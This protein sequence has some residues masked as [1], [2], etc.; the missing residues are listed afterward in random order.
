[1]PKAGGSNGRNIEK[2][3]LLEM[4]W[5]GD[6]DG[7][8]VGGDGVGWR[9]CGLEMWVGMWVGMMLVEMMWVGM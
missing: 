4:V 7:D 2:V 9:W 6:V 3:L 5:V 1:M 8:D